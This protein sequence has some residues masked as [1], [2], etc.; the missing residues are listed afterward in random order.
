MISLVKMT[1]RQKAL[2]ER[3]SIRLVLVLPASSSCVTSMLSRKQHKSWKLGK[4]CS[5]RYVTQFMLTFS[6]P[7]PVLANVLRECVDHTQQTW[8]ITGYPVIVFGITSEPARVPIGILS[9]FKHEVT[10]EASPTSRCT[11]KSLSLTLS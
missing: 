2:F 5:E 1:Q 3:D 6:F 9:C 11:S 8:K 10:F 4:V 7:E